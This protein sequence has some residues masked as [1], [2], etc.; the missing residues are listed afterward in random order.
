MND[1][2]SGMNMTTMY[3]YRLRSSWNSSRLVIAVLLRGGRDSMTRMNVFLL[4]LLAIE[5]CLR[6]LTALCSLFCQH[7]LQSSPIDHFL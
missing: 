3:M 1:D 7:R 4:R 6:A 2:G 5:H